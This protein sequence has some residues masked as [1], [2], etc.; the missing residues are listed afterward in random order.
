MLYILGLLGALMI[1]V[2]GIMYVLI[3]GPSRYHRDGCVGALSRLLTSLPDRV[4]EATCAICCGGH[5]ARGKQAWKR[6]GDH[7]WG[8]NWI[9][10]GL[11]IL[12]FWTPEALYLFWCLPLLRTSWIA[13][14]VS[15]L[16]VLMSEVLYGA[17]VFS[18]PGTVS[19][20]AQV[21]RQLQHL[22]KEKKHS[23][24]PSGGPGKKKNQNGGGGS[25]SCFPC[26]PFRCGT[27]QGKMHSLSESV[28]KEYCCNRR[29]P[30]DDILYS[31]QPH[32]SAPRRSSRSRNPSAVSASSTPSSNTESEHSG[33]RNALGHVVRFGL[34]CTTCRLPKPSRSKHCKLC[35]RCVRRFDHHCPWINNDVGEGTQR[36]FIGFIFFHT[37]S[38][39]WASLDLWAIMR[40]FL[41]DH[42]MWGWRYVRSD[43]HVMPLSFSHYL[44][45]LT[46]YQVLPLALFIFAL[47]MGLVLFFFFSYVFSFA[48]WNITLNDMEKMDMVMDYFDSLSTPGEM[49]KEACEVL[50]KLE[51][52]Y[53]RPKRL[54]PLKYFP[55]PSSYVENLT[56]REDNAK[57]LVNPPPFPTSS[58]APHSLKELSKQRK[59]YVKKLRRV[60]RKALKGIYDRGILLNLCE[61]F[62]PYWHLSSTQLARAAHY[63]PSSTPLLESDAST[64]FLSAGNQ[65]KKTMG[66]GKK[67]Q[68]DGSG[69]EKGSQ[70][71]SSSASSHNSKTF[72]GCSFQF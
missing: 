18:D 69:R 6:F 24:R 48:L 38:C 17:A 30:V 4:G 63:I 5:S 33:Y 12:L 21:R 26:P 57:G 15:I 40:Q 50:K 19:T 61:V 71:S 67:K 11:Y 65:D 9:L 29:Y 1:F 68:Y 58:S 60:L 55:P 45:I 66:K 54:A 28:A 70:L 32:P 35:N 13:K 56:L 42:H 36:Y 14:S 62:F 10:V 16:L 43:R 37:I 27:D 2:S 3:L 52:I 53:P 46:R 22:E 72:Y 25:G 51:E 8:R 41:M 34:P 44:I 31:I 7:L 39:V 23:S 20:A 59:T 64:S 47:L 49:Y